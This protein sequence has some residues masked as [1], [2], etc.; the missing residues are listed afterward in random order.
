MDEATPLAQAQDEL[1]RI[2]HLIYVS[3]KY[4]RTCDIF[5]NIIDRLINCIGF[6]ID[7]LLENLEKEN[8]IFEVPSQPGSKCNVVKEH[9]QD[10]TILKMVQF[11]LSLRQMNRAEFSREREYR[12]HVTMTMNI[13]GEVVEVNIDSMTQDFKDTKE[14]V[15]HAAKYLGE[16]ND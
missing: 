11:Y 7:A 8:K 9:I 1:K 3:L 14:Y 6:V 13:D 4:T 10:E 12:R 5:K 2:D 15:I 16:S